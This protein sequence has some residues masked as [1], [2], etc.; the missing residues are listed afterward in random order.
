MAD[1]N[2]EEHIN[3]LHGELVAKAHDCSKEVRG[4]INKLPG[5]IDDERTVTETE[6]QELKKQLEAAKATME[7]KAD[8]SAQKCGKR[9]TDKTLLAE[10]EARVKAETEVERLKAEVAD[11]TTLV[12]E[13]AALRSRLQRFNEMQQ[14]KEPPTGPAAM[15]G[16]TNKINNKGEDETAQGMPN[17][18]QKVGG[19]VERQA[20]YP[21]PMGNI[22]RPLPKGRKHDREET[23][24]LAA[25]EELL[26]EGMDDGREAKRTKT[27][28]ARALPVCGS[29]NHRKFKCDAKAP[30]CKH[31]AVGRCFYRPCRDGVGCAKQACHF[32]HPDQSVTEDGRRM[33]S[34]PKAVFGGR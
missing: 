32:L 1:T 29:C 7:K 17:P 21:Q 20:V 19:G 13:N 24:P 14:G 15:C 2:K 33:T 3:K 12:T 30:T 10:K 8:E 28:D 31:C 11:K 22:H 27:K 23:D 34:D 5:A 18:E 26:N 9:M 4:L 6:M 16:N 25:L